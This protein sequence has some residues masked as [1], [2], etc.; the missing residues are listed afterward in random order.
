M[1]FLAFTI[2]MPM[3]GLHDVPHF[4][5]MMPAVGLLFFGMLFL[6][7]I[8]MIPGWDYFSACCSSCSPL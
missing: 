6:M 8:A 3:V 1:L 4:T 7:F 2:M 5:V